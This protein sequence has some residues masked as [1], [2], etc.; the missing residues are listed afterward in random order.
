MVENSSVFHHIPEAKLHLPLTTTELYCMRLLVY[1]ASPRH[2]CTFLNLN[3]SELY[4]LQGHM[5]SKFKRNSWYA[6]IS[7]LLAYDHTL[8]HH[9]LCPSHLKPIALSHATKILTLHE[10]T[11]D[12]VAFEVMLQT[13]LQHF[14]KAA[15]AP[16]SRLK[17]LLKTLS[18]KEVHIIRN[19]MTGFNLTRHGYR[20]Y[21]IKIG[22]MHL[23]KR[24]DSHNH[25]DLLRKI[26][27][28]LK[29]P[30]IVLEAS[31]QTAEV[32]RVLNNSY[33]S[34]W[35][36][37]LSLQSTLLKIYLQEELRIATQTPH[38]SIIQLLDKKIIND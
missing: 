37:Q 18:K 5:Y 3:Y 24:F 16:Y 30:Q 35:E 19:M 15:V 6:T 22:K 34:K 11:I 7:I 8:N 33:L 4:Y 38:K 27:L 26:L 32:L 21:Q 23:Y 14:F 20:A 2:M 25:F 1:N 31:L 28:V 12:M 17:L 13:L 29:A 9:D 10:E 36:K